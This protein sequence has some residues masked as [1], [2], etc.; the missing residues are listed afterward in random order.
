MR[1]AVIGSGIIGAA[2][3]DRL[4]AEGAAVTVVDAARPGSV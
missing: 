4:V 3:A 1:I 2:V